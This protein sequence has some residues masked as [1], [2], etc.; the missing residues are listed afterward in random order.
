MFDEDCIVSAIIDSGSYKM[1]LHNHFESDTVKYIKQFTPCVTKK[2]P[3]GDRWQKTT[4]VGKQIEE[5]SETEW[6]YRNNPLQRGHVS[7]WQDIETIWYYSFY[8]ELRIAPEETPTIQIESPIVTSRER[9]KLIQIMFETFSVPCLYVSQTGPLA[10][11]YL[12]KSIGI[13]I[14][15]GHESTNIM[16]V[17]NGIL[18]RHAVKSLPLGGKDITDYLIHLNNL[19]NN[20]DEIFP[21]F[22]EFKEN[23]SYVSRNFQNECEI[24]RFS[25]NIEKD[26][27]LP[28]GNLFSFGIERSTCTEILFQP[29]LFQCNSKG[30]TDLI[31]DCINECDESIRKDLKNNVVLIGSTSLCSGLEERLKMELGFDFRITRPLHPQ[32]I[33]CLGGTKLSMSPEFMHKWIGKEDYD[34]HG[35]CVIHKKCL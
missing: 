4:F 8:S 23:Y 35:P 14:D 32:F 29:N 26:L 13:V 15:F 9:E 21:Y 34:E 11:E 1:K 31:L 24:A 20:Y 30:I 7:N 12:N 10:L 33:G 28:D 18:I 3:N 6:I 16:P 27:E 17:Y 5:E 19:N 25:H 2:K 22:N